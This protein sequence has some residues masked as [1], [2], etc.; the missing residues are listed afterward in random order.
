MPRLSLRCLCLVAFCLICP[1]ASR[2]QQFEFFP[3]GTYDP[4]VPTPESVLGYPIGTYH[5]NYAG[6][7][8]WLAALKNSPRVRLSEYGRSYEKRVLH[9]VIISS[10]E[11]LAR[12]DAVRDAMRRLSDP[13]TTTS[14]EAER[15]AREF[16][17][18]AWMN[19]AN[20]G[21]ESAAFEAA[22][23]TSYQLAAGTDEKT[24]TI[25]DRLVVIIN[26]AHNPESHERFVAWYNSVQ[27][28]RTG[29]PDPHAAEHHAPWGMST[30]NNHYQIDLNRDAFFG[31]QI[32]TQAI[33][34]A[35]GEWNP[36]V[37][38]DHHG[39]TKNMF[40]PPPAEAINLNVTA[41]QLDWMNRYGNAIGAAFDA[42]GWSY[43]RG[44]RFDLFYAGFWDSWPTLNGAI[45]MTFETDGGGRNGLAMEREDGTTLTL[46]DGVVHHFTATMATLELTAGNKE[47]RLRDLYEYKRS[48][49]DEGRREPMKQVVL[50]PGKDATR[51]AMLVDTLRAQRI[52]VMRARSPIKLTKAHSFFGGEAVA[53]EI[54]AGAYVIS[55]AQP[56]KR[57]ARAIL[58]PDPEFRKEFLENEE[59]KKRRSML[60]GDR[61]R[62]GFYDTTAW[63]LPILYGVEAWW[64]ED[65]AAGSGLERVEGEIA[66]PRAE[67]V[68]SSYGYLISPE[69]FG[70]M[71]LVARLLSEGFNAAVATEPFRLS[72]RDFPR[73]SIILRA[74]RNPETLYDRIVALAAEAKAEVLGL[75][76]ARVEAG[77]DFGED[78]YVELRAPRIAVVTGEP[79]DERAYGAAWFTL[80][81]RLGM[82]FTPIRMEQLK[83]APLGRYQ[84]IIFPHGSPAEYQEMLGEGGVARLKRWMEEGGT[85]VLI[86]GAAAMATRREVEWTRSRLKRG[87]AAV[88]LFFDEPGAATVTV[89]EEEREKDEGKKEVREVDLAR[90]SGALLRVKVDAEHYLG[91]GYNGDIGA[92]IASNYAFT[93]SGS[94]RSVAAF[95]DQRVLRLGGFIWPE[96]QAALARSPYLWREGI[97]RGQAILFADDPNFRATQLSTMR[98]FW[99]AV[100][101]GPSFVN[102][103]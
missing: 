71:R 29:S 24:R 66:L 46:R 4:A 75:N 37:F 95:P 48:A 47:Q 88:G 62:D 102:W 18:V 54:P 14:A 28:G 103:R 81:E 51:A 68:R 99:N 41:N 76:S 10:P 21:N 12:L 16:P 3:G 55:M 11:N 43:Y 85:L 42:R 89:T 9:L 96:A 1:V 23:Q 49:I 84:V 2:A 70:S 52:E 8:R 25:L 79:T 13:R 50:L 90:T 93:I 77:P 5:T 7:E 57:L 83:S 61:H 15:I 36:A 31:T 60:T 20:D 6:L 35:F 44:G 63:S 98:L 82:P 17:A 101:L 74:E 53:R 58:E 64:A 30:N 59:R 39:E 40:F 56:Q 34:R 94:G 32:E 87:E 22:I 97:G 45:G 26:P 33:V 78:P 67:T 69:S 65:E 86:K 27:M 92:T 91:Y 38:V 100:L 80:E 19:Y 73:G 72:G